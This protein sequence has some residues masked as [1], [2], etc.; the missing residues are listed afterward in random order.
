MIAIIKGDIVSSRKLIDQE[1]WLLP[2][3]SLLSTW[4]N[5]PKQWELV[6]GDFF[7]VEITH[8]EDALKRALEIKALI[9]KIEPS[10]ERKNISPIDVRMAIG[11]GEKTYS[12]DSISESNGSAFIHAGEKFDKLKKE[13]TKLGIKSPLQSLDNEINLYLKLAGTFMDRWS[14][15]SAELIS[16]ILKNPEIKQE[17]IGGLLDIKQNSVS[18]RRNRANADE[19]L[20]VERVYRQKIK[21]L[22]I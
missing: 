5:T 6:W 8:A 17:E 14:V 1:K 2:L 21:Q 9:K 20:E 13:N 7:Q 19:I 10:N 12:G 3:K 22:L 4:G 18:G 11:L 16:I 15:S